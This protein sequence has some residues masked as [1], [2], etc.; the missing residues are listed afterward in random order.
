MKL[1]TPDKA[2]ALMTE[3]AA[4]VGRS[5]VTAVGYGVGLLMLVP[6][7]YL[8][9]LFP[10]LVQPPFSGAL[11]QKAAP[12]VTIGVDAIPRDATGRGLIPV[13]VVKRACKPNFWLKPI[14]GRA[15]Y[16]TLHVTGG[17]QGQTADVR[18][19]CATYQ[20]IT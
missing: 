9:A 20:A 2:S 7:W 15:P 8:W 14:M 12:T 10:V 13:D 18:V 1:T 11:F 17:P 4:S 16:T 6:V 5:F 19:S 3:N